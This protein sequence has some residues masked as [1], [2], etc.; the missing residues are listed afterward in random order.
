MLDYDV[1]IREEGKNNDTQVTLLGLSTCGFCKRAVRWLKEQ[2]VSFQYSYIDKI[3]KEVKEKI[4]SEI[5]ERF[6]IKLLYPILIVEEKKTVT[7]FTPEKYRKAL[8]RETEES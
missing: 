7:G 3:D 6:D 2:E 1:F 8:N 4:K 5:R